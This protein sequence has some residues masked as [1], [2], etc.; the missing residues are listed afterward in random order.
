MVEFEGNLYLTRQAFADLLGV[1][2]HALS[3]RRA[4]GSEV[5]EAFIHRGK[6]YYSLELIKE[7][8]A[9]NPIVTSRISKLGPP[10]PLEG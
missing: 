2:I 4:R 7:S 3:Q 5:V 6:A 1:T 8:Y 9:K 10:T